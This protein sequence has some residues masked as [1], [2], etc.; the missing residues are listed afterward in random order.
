MTS[1]HVGKKRQ[2]PLTDQVTVVVL[3]G[4]MER[5]LQPHMLHRPAVGGRERDERDRAAW[6]GQELAA[7]AAAVSLYVWDRQ[8]EL[9]VVMAEQLEIATEQRIAVLA[10]SA[11]LSRDQAVAA[12]GEG[13]CV[14]TRSQKPSPAEI[15]PDYSQVPRDSIAVESQAG[16]GRRVVQ[17]S[18]LP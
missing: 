9:D 1:R 7:V 18:P 10:S 13:D 4:D 6:H 3:C 11:T 16:G 2:R 17:S 8:P 5:P 12:Y 14:A 15:V